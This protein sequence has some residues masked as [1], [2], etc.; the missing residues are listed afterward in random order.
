MVFDSFCCLKV[1]L[2]SNMYDLKWN[3]AQNVHDRLLEC[4]KRI[5]DCFCTHFIFYLLYFL[6]WVKDCLIYYLLY[7]LLWIN[8]IKWKNKQIECACPSLSS[9]VPCDSLLLELMCSLPCYLGSESRAHLMY[10]V[11]KDKV[12]NINSNF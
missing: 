12:T 11:L 3:T 6:W 5:L 7:L 9:C 2:Y 8:S 10:K 1:T 4:G